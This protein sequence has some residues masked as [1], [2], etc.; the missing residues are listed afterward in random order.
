[1]SATL[2]SPVLRALAPRFWAAHLAVMASLAICAWLGMWQYHAWEAR[3]AAAAVDLTT[4]EP[5]PLADAMGPDDP[6]PGNDLGQPVVVDGTWVPEGTVYVSGREH[7][8]VDGYWAVTPLAIGGPDA[9]AMLVVRGWSATL[10]DIPAPPTGEAELVGF[11]QP[12]EGATDLPDEDPADDLLPQLRIADAIQHVDQ[13]L[14]GA[15]VVVADTVAPGDWPAGDR[16]VNAGTTGLTAADLDQQPDVGRFTALRNL[17]Y[18]FQWWVFG[19]F[20]AFVWWRFMADSLAAEEASA[21]GEAVDPDRTDESTDE[22]A[23]D[24]VVTEG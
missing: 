11:L 4:K 17:L 24:G 3:R 7:D 21:Y 18:A 6:F 1:M 20:A 14:Y 5:I 23:D 15:Y 8:G 9:P 13:D 12:P 16:A 19:A 10:D 2:R 22:S